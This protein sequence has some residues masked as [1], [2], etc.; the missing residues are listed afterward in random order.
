VKAPLDA[1]DRAAGIVYR[2]RVWPGWVVLVERLGPRKWQAAEYVDG[3]YRPGSKVIT[4]TK[5]HAVIHA[6]GVAQDYGEQRR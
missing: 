3:K 5:R 2:E 6:Q 4:Q 1:F